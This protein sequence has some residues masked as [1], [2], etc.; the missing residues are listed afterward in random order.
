MSNEQPTLNHIC[1]RLSQ[2]SSSDWVAVNFQEQMSAAD[3]GSVRF[4]EAVHKAQ[5]KNVSLS[6]NNVRCDGVRRCFGWLSQSKIDFVQGKPK[7]E[8]K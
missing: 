5:N 7:K 8:R 4:C 3:V 6:F 2:I 1:K